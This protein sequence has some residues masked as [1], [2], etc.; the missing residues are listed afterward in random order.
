MDISV[1][2]G[3]V[4]FLVDLGQHVCH[5]GHTDTHS[6]LTLHNFVHFAQIAELGFD[7]PQLAES[8]QV[9]LVKLL[10]RQTDLLEGF[11]DLGIVDLPRNAVREE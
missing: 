6:D 2:V 8:P 4:G 10:F 7:A 5:P 3:R 1:D 11:L 9:V